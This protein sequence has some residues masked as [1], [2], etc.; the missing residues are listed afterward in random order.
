MSLEIP[1]WK[2]V[3]N[4][5]KELKTVKTEDL[6]LDVDNASHPTKREHAIPGAI[7][8][9]TAANIAG[10][11]QVNCCCCCCC[12][13]WCCYCCCCLWCSG[14]DKEGHGGKHCR[15]K[16]G[17]LF[18]VMLFMLLFMLLLMLLLL[19]FMGYW[20]PSRGTLR[21][22]LQEENRFLFFFCYCCC[23]CC[24]GGGG[25]GCGY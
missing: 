24:C 20:A 18:I 22:T 19:L 1:T 13:C 3:F 17:K 21:Q 11:K 15:R 14:C 23:C 5:R 4:F 7:K 12:C 8:R 6:D 16:T 2:I 10:G 9:D 25:G